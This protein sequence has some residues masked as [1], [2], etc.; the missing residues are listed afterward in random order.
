MVRRILALSILAA[1][2]AAG[3]GTAMEPTTSDRISVIRNQ[4]GYFPCMDC[5]GDQVPDPRVRIMEEEH[6][7]PLAYEDENGVTHRITFG[8]RVPI[9]ELLTSSRPGELLSDKIA[10]VGRG[11]GIRAYMEF[12]GLTPGDSVWVML[13]GGGNI[14]CLNCHDEKDRDKLIKLNGEKITFNQSHLLCGECH[15]SILT[16][17]DRG[18]HGKTTGYWSAALDSDGISVR[19]LCVECHNPH[20][21]PF[22]PM[23]ALP[24]PVTRFPRRHVSDGHQE[25]I[26][27]D[28][29]IGD[30]EE[31]H[32]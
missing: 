23:R 5:H 16:D 1:L 25:R 17:W 29:D 14:W 22:P 2:L 4:L 12:N 28:L 15:G 27:D 31:G 10:K 6:A 18:I 20:D 8:V 11:I 26:L 24:P 30:G 21:P 19:K 9:S 32:E 7:E 3:P 13:H